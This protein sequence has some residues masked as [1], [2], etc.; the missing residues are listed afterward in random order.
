MIG[1]TH[2]VLPLVLTSSA[3]ACRTCCICALTCPDME[4]AS[5]RGSSTGARAADINVLSTSPQLVPVGWTEEMGGL[6]RG[7]AQQGVAGVM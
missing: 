6:G 2:A 5:S 1:V 3:D 4:L 7:D